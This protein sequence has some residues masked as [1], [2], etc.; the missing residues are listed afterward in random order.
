ML[1]KIKIRLPA[2]A[3]NLGPGLYSLG[4]ALG[5]YTTVEISGRDDH[6]L[7]V[8]LQGE[9]ATAFAHVVRHPV[10]V[11]MAQVFQ[12]LED[13]RLGVQ[14]KVH[15]Q[16]P[17]NCG[18]GAES[19]FTMAGVLGANYLMDTQYKRDELLKIAAEIAQTEGVIAS[20][21]GGLTAGV[22]DKDGLIFDSLPV[23]PF[24]VVVVVPQIGK[25]HPP[26]LPEQ[27]SRHDVLHNLTRVPLLVEA[28][29]N[30]D[31]HLLVRL[32]DDRILM[33]RMTSQITG[34]GHVVE[35]AR[36][37]GALGVTVCGQGPTLLAFAESR[38]QRVAE[39]MVLAFRSAGVEAR[40]W[41]LP[42]DMQGVVISAVQSV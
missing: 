3:T 20:L 7:K 19:A 10:V 16:I 8:E 42:V 23:Q 28:L 2:T 15:N 33:P 25:Y 26:R 13:T 11:A 35:I 5:L 31:L 4:L 41:V 37:R 12:R 1:Q 29:R 32:L 34:Y 14:I 40:S 36:S 21:L 39:D 9:G 24:Q 27:L 17:L 18:L 6:E 22:L 30:G 38:H